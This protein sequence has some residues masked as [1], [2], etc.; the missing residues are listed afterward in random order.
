M[1]KKPASEKPEKDCGCDCKVCKC[2][3]AAKG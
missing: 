3:G 1:E 2:K